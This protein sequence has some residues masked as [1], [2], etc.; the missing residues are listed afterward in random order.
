VLNFPRYKGASVLLARAN[1]GCGSAV[2]TPPG[3]EGLCF[4]VVIAPSY[5]DIFYT[6][7][8][9]TASAPP[10]CRRA[11]RRIFKRTEKRKA[12]R[13]TVNLPNQTV[14]DKRGLMFKFEIAPSRK[15]VC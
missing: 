1:F 4:R 2:N 8:S 12:I 15:E 13:L 14:A 5:A 3:R 11:G 9:R 7:V 6:I 10:R